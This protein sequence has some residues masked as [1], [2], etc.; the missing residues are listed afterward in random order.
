MDFNLPPEEYLKKINDVEIRINLILDEL[1]NTYV[2]YKLYPDVSEYQNVYLNNKNN[3]ENAHNDYF[4]L[5]NYLQSN[6]MNQ[7]KQI[8]EQGKTIDDL[9]KENLSLSNRYKSLLLGNN[10]A[11]GLNYQQEDLYTLSKYNFVLTMISILCISFVTKNAFD[12]SK[13]NK[14]SPVPVAIENK[15]SEVVQDKN[16]IS[17]SENKK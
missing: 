10:A 13:K 5:K 7:K 9:K 16:L 14:S 8:E 1:K 4:L 15:P 17:S 11:I 2:N 6:L 3:L 12:S